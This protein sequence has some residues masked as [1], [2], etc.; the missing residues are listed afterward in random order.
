M[1]TSHVKLKCNLACKR[2][3]NKPDASGARILMVAGKT[4]EGVEKCSTALE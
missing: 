1:A 3:D 4:N 2:D